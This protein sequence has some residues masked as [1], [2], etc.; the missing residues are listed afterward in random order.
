MVGRLRAWWAERG[1]RVDLARVD[2][3][4]PD[5]AKRRTDGT[6]P[7]SAGRQPPLRGADGAEQDPRANAAPPPSPARESGQRLAW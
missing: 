7:D 3:A 4:L 2:L 5:S 1:N 6:A